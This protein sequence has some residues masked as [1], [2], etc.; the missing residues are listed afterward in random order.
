MTSAISSEQSDDPH[1]PARDGLMDN[2][3]LRPPGR[4]DLGLL[5]VLTRRLLSASPLTLARRNMLG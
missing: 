4:G 3:R 5:P 2:M 1:V